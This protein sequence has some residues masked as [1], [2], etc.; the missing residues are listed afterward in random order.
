MRL[1]NLS[2]TAELEKSGFSKPTTPKRKADD[3]ENDHLA[4]IFYESPPFKRNGENFSKVPPESNLLPPPYLSHSSVPPF[5]EPDDPR[6]PTKS[7]E[8][9]ASSNEVSTIDPSMLLNRTEQQ[10]A[11]PEMEDK[12]GM[13]GIVQSRHDARSHGYTLG[14]YVPEM[15][16]DDDDVDSE[17]VPPQ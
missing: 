13:M 14:S 8:A 3:A 17:Q 4:P 7:S 1:D 9:L 16:T 11:G 5:A 12:G 6:M 2:F 15:R 10:S